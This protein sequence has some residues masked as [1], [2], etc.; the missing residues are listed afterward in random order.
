MAALIQLCNRALRAIAA[1]EIAAFSE[2]SIEAKNANA[3]AQPLLNEMA[4]WSDAF[5][6][7]RKRVVLAE[8]DND[9]PA[10]WLYAYTAPSDLGTPIAVRMVEDDAYGLPLGGPFTFP[11]QERQP[12]AFVHEEGRIY[13]NV[14]TA[15]LIYTRAEIAASELSP[16]GQKAFVDELAARLAV[17]VKK[18][19]GNDVQQLRKMAEA[20]RA[21]WVADEE[22][23]TPRRE[24]GYIS[25][26]EYARAGIGV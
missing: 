26:V 22:N 2:P 12:L 16:L 6:F 9:R 3:E 15:T 21:R 24:A 20:S 4:E 10:E 1:G 19:G 7:G 17:P 18:A 11:D 13:S 8:I 25:E 5:G 23:K 14:E